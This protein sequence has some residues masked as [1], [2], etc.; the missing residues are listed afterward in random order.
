[1]AQEPAPGG[2]FHSV[3]PSPPPSTAGSDVVSHPLLPQ[4]R[5]NPLR[6]G[7]QKQSSLI[8][9]VDTK[10]LH[11]SRRYEKRFDGIEN[12]DNEEERGYSSFAEM[13]KDL[14]AIVDVVWI[15]ATR[16]LPTIQM[17][18]HARPL[19]ASSFPPKSI[20]AHDRFDFV[21]CALRIS[22]LSTCHI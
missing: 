9:Y 8:D 21:H 10:L 20:P 19:T 2:F 4:H 11:I 3:L 18:G 22:F 1:M 5:A 12:S 6:P 13:A 16:M 15:S 14:D 17:R 7:S